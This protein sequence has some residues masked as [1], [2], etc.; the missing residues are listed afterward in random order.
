MALMR[1]ADRERAQLLVESSSRVQLNA[2]LKQ[3][4]QVLMGIRTSVHWVVDVD[5]SDI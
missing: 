2:F 4:C 1:V 3:W 5:P